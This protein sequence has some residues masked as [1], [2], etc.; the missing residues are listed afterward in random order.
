MK[1]FLI[2]LF[3]AS[4][5]FSAGYAFY[6]RIPLA[7]DAK[8]YDAIAWNLVEGYGYKENRNLSYE[9]DYALGRAGPG[10]EFFL[11]G[12]YTIFGHRHWPVW[13]LQSIFHIL[14]GIFIFLAYRLLTKDKEIT[15]PVILGLSLF[16]F[17]PD[18]I[19]VNAMILT[20]PLFILLTAAS[21]FLGLKLLSSDAPEILQTILFAVLVSCAGLVRPVA[22]LFFFI[23]ACAFL[24]KRYW[25]R[26]LIVISIF[27]LIVGPWVLRNYLRHGILFTNATGGLELWVS[28][29]PGSQ[30]EFNV[31]DEVAAY[32]E[33]HGLFKTAERGKAEFVKF[34]FKH[35]LSF[36][37]KQIEKTSIYFSMLRTS[38]FWLY[39]SGFKQILIILS[40]AA[41]NIILFTLGLA[42]FYF[43]FKERSF[44]KKIFLL[45]AVSI[46]ASIIPVLVTGRYRYVL[47]IFLVV[48]AIVSLR[49]ILL[50]KY[51]PKIIW[52][53]L[54]LLLLNTG[55]D[56]VWHFSKVVSHIAILGF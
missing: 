16:L 11:A 19:Q 3:L 30:G 55:L 23:F 37:L 48:G 31:N 46:P 51:I 17:H 33:E 5:L 28:I 39:L 21:L 20:E 4:F 29:L 18:L 42:G 26:A 53:M 47:F 27:L 35:P 40:S 22:F 14:S 1:S 52:F 43:L 8:A 44:L 2:H 56:A 7:V 49:F 45:A 10:Y 24:Y 6:S 34:I 25:R 9:E 38:G 50:Q 36:L 32:F 13:I 54:A 12:A 41:F 15:W